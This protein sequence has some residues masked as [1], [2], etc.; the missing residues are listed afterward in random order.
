MKT[1]ISI[2][3]FFFLAGGG[4]AHAQTQ[5]DRTQVKETGVTDAV[6]ILVTTVMSNPLTADCKALASVLNEVISRGETGGKNSKKNQPFD[7]M[8]GE[9][10]LK[11]AIADPNTRGRVEKIRADVVD[12]G[13]R[14]VYEA[15]ILEEEGYRDARDLKLHQLQQ[16]LY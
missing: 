8:K 14:A 4:L 6:L 16:R 10:E 11:K 9:A 2:Y 3:L 1:V 5:C 15:A 13:A 12:E 7:A